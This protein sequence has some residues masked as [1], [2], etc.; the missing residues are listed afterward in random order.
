MCNGTRQRLSRVTVLLKH[1]PPQ[2]ALGGQ[3]FTLG[4][5]HR[6]RE[7]QS[8]QMPAVSRPFR[9]DRSGRSKQT[10]HLY[11]SL[12]PRRNS[13]RLRHTLLVACRLSLLNLWPLSIPSWLLLNWPVPSLSMSRVVSVLLGES[14]CPI[15]ASA[16]SLSVPESAASKA[17][18][19]ANGAWSAIAIELTNSHICGTLKSPK[20][21][22][23]P[24]A[25]ASS[26][27]PLIARPA[28]VTSAKV[29]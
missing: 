15:V 12:P 21:L 3:S 2:L 17:P 6:H 1:L 24:E 18:G 10:Q 9:I 23:I 28:T 20:L 5:F 22:G 26:G 8:N 16:A 14:I 7:P 13:V 25:S 19:M 27:T 4:R 11:E 29:H